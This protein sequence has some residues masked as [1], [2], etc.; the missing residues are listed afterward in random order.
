MEA[1]YNRQV[2][3]IISL[4]TMGE[5][6]FALFIMAFLP[7]LCEETLFRGGFQNFLSRGTG[8]PWVSIIIVSFL[9]SLAHFSFYG[10]LSRFFLGMVLGMI[11][12]YSGKLW[13]SILAHFVHNAAAL[14]FLYISVKDKKGLGEA[15]SNDASSAWGILALPVVIGLF[16]LFKRASPPTR[17]T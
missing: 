9:F 5:Y 7:A 13:L 14:T 10:F 16:I 4:N 8:R 17:T 3:A 2:Q 15:L 1:D 6:L 11:Y 12:H